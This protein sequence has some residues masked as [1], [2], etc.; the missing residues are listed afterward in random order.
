LKPCNFI[1]SPVT[2]SKAVAKCICFLTI[3]VLLLG[4]RKIKCLVYLKR[5]K[6]TTKAVTNTDVRTS[7]IEV[8]TGFGPVQFSSA[9][10][11]DN[12]PAMFPLM[13]ETDWMHQQKTPTPAE[14]LFSC[15]SL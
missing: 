7:N 11:S 8:R 14:S 9:C 15:H 5:R 4:H 2:E 12:F 10:E 3:V 1:P 13:A 6:T